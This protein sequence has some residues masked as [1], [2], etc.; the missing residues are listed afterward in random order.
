LTATAKQIFEASE[1]IEA[2]QRLALAA[3]SDATP[4]NHWLRS[5]SS[6]PKGAADALLTSHVASPGG[7]LPFGIHDMHRFHYS[8]A[9]VGGCT[10]VGVG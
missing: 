9:V 1:P 6:L 7:T 10:R 5:A 4:H 3:Q 2:S 8:A